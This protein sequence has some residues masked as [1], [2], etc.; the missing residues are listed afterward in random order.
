MP[1]T[2]YDLIGQIIHPRPSAAPAPVQTH[3]S[4]APGEPVSVLIGRI[5]APSGPAIR[6]EATVPVAAPAV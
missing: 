1:E 2:V 5:V 4:A 6:A 3:A